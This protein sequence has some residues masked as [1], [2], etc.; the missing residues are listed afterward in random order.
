MLVFVE[1]PREKTSEQGGQPT[2]ILTGDMKPDLEF[3]ESGPDPGHSGGS[4][5]LSP[6]RHPHSIVNYTNKRLIQWVRKLFAIATY[7]SLH[8][9]LLL[10]EELPSVISIHLIVLAIIVHPNRSFCLSFFPES[11]LERFG[12]SPQDS[13]RMPDPTG[14]NLSTSYKLKEVSLPK[15]GK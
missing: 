7:A 15:E 6:L 5:A 1:G 9:D 14:Q 11:T 4:Q 13:F 8:H 10:R 2:N 3:R 12:C